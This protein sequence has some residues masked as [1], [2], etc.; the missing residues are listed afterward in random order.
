MITNIMSVDLEDYFCDLPFSQW[1][2][3]RSRIVET[4][5]PLLEFFDNYNIKATFFVV[6][7]FAEKFPDLIKKIHDKGHE[8]GTH[9]YSHID[10]RKTSKEE[11]IKDLEKSISSLESITG[12]KIL[13]F[14]APFFSI[15]KKNTLVMKILKKYF[16]YDSSIFPVKTP[17]YGLPSAPREIYHPSN[18]DLTINDEHESFIEIP[19]LTF[20]LLNYNIPMAGGFYFRFFPNFLIKN[21][22]K[23][24]NKKNQPAMLYIHPK[25]LDLKMPKI[26]NYDWHYYY[27]KNNIEKKFLDL[28]RCFKFTSAKELLNL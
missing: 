13:G 6:G 15:N 2:N 18:N 9:T 20:K 12:E 28:L 14:R 11:L 5:N 24:F 10:L 23:S 27:G 19:P 26:T 16:Q 22:I 25:D 1:P 3:Y 21:A 8:I 17:L 7:Y 4:T